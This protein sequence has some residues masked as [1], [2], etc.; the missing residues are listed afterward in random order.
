MQLR[1]LHRFSTRSKNILTSNLNRDPILPR[2]CRWFED[3]DPI[4]SRFRQGLE[5]KDPIMPKFFRRGNQDKMLPRYGLGLKIKI[6]YYQ[7]FVGDWKSRSDT[8]KISLGIGN[9]RFDIAKILSGVGNQEPILPRFRCG[10]KTKIL[11][12]CHGFKEFFNVI[13]QE[14]SLQS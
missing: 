12:Y 6:L 8:A 11:R 3:K 13:A 1:S 2:F 10:W 9:Q 7:D 4:M 5:I 14:I